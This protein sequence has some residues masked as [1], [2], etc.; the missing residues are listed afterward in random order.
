MPTRMRVELRRW[1]RRADRSASGSGGLVEHPAVAR[2]VVSGHESIGQPR[3]IQRTSVAVLV[4]Q[5]ASDLCP[6][7]TASG[8]GMTL[9]LKSTSYARRLPWWHQSSTFCSSLVV[10]R[11]AR[12]CRRCE[13]RRAA[14]RR[15][16]RSADCGATGTPRRM[17]AAGRMVRGSPCGTCD[18]LGPGT[19]PR[20]GDRACRRRAPGRR[21][22]CRAWPWQ[23]TQLRSKIGLMSR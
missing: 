7:A 6:T 1:R 21:R 17:H 18:V 23:A 20:L 22:A 5:A 15:P 19:R 11:R 8:G 9:P 16:S 3:S 2:G 12:R 10:E 4:G 14:G 13:S